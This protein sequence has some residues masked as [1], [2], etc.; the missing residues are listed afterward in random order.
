MFVPL[1][2]TGGALGTAY[3]Q[4][5]VHSPS[6][7]LYAAV[8]MASFISAAYKTPLAAVVFVA[9]ATGGHAFLIPALIAAA[10]AYAVSG[11]A[12]ASADQR[13]HEGVKVQDLRNISV[14]E[15]MQRQMI[16]V[17][18][19]LSAGEFISMF[20]PH[21]PHEAFPVFDG[22]TPV[23][24]ITP[25]SVM[26]VSPD[27]WRTTLVGE[28]AENGMNKVSPECDVMEALRLLS[29]EHRQTMLLVVS[30]QGSIEGIVTKSDI[31]QA[32]NS[33]GQDSVKLHPVA[34]LD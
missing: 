25:W 17:Q 8:G 21:S 15:V 24:V 27:T 20:S 7:G 22:R 32:L 34:E 28:L 13:L 31:L 16:S 18:A 9:E 33:R 14:S 11:D 2:L 29:S 5:V 12:S 10:V 6:L 1:F 19:S 3:A 4:S 26:K 30:A 23:G